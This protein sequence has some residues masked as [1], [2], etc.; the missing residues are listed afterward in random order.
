MGKWGLMQVE[1][2]CVFG[3]APFSLGWVRSYYLYLVVGLTQFPLIV[4]ENY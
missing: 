1:E 2:S 4:G 3:M